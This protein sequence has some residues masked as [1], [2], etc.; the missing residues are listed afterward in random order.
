MKPNYYLLAF[1]ACGVAARAQVE[2]PT[3]GLMLDGKSALRPVYGVAASATLGDAVARKVDGFACAASYCVV[4]TDG[5]I[6]NYDAGAFRE[7][8]R[9][10][11]GPVLIA[12]DANG[13]FLY[14]GQSGKVTRL[15][16]AAAGAEPSLWD[17]TS[18]G[19]VLALRSIGENGFDYAVRR[20]GGVW[21]EHFSISD[22]G[23]AVLGG[24]DVGQGSESEQSTA[25]NAVF[26]LDDGYLASTD[27][28]VVL[29]RWEGSKKDF[30]APGVQAFLAMSSEYVEAVGDQGRWVLSVTRGA[31]S[32][33]LLPGATGGAE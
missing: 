10:A 2:R 23:I 16:R 13:A 6:A 18:E 3:L 17:F 25:V 11:D 7:L 20:E 28:G 19:E 33:A 31:E 15:D 29:V 12:A 9:G 4:S 5:V 22:G 8:A 32:L 1:L 27:Q 21:I 14:F 24:V 30:P 26:L